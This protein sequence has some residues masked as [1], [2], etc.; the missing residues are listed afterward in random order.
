[1]NTVARAGPNQVCA[2]PW[3]NPLVHVTRSRVTTPRY[4]FEEVTKQVRRDV[5]RTCITK[6]TSMTIAFDLLQRHIQT[7]VDDHE[8]W[9][10]LIADDMVWELAYAPAIG[11]P[12]RLSG[13]EEVMHHVTWLYSARW[14]T[15][16][17]SM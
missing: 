9:Q 10:T 17:S 7:L 14:K 5:E 12:A 11:H 4:S 13:R 6:E 16:A 8:P 2:K 15:S 3:A 1:M